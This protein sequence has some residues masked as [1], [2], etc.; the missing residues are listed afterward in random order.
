MDSNPAA[1]LN[2]LNKSTSNVDVCSKKSVSAERTCAEN[3]TAEWSIVYF[4]SDKEENIEGFNDLIPSS[5]ITAKGALS[6]YPM[7]EHRGTIKKLVK[8]CGKPNL[9]WN[10]YSI[11]KIEESIENFDRGMK[12]LVKI[13]K[14][15][16]A[17]LYSDLEEK[18]KGKRK[19]R[20]TK[21]F[22]K[23]DSD[24]DHFDKENN[25]E[26]R[27]KKQST[28]PPFPKL[29]ITKSV[30]VNQS[31]YDKGTKRFNMDKVPS[32]LDNNEQ[33]SSIISHHNISFREISRGQHDMKYK[34]IKSLQESSVSTDTRKLK[35]TILLE[36]GLKSLTV[37]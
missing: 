29:N 4:E 13:A 11:K 17:T 26:K 23:D 6:W 8:Q 1:D 20:P 21:Y 35:P 16:N 5:W 32:S 30:P 19:K 10:C 34:E 15:P 25:H 3:N 28:V 2:L 31:L 33:Q 37:E 22:D 24:K 27:Q 9:E 7:N 14:N 18:G 12:V 36:N